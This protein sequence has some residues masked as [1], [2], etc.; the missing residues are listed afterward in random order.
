M[1]DLGE[2]ARARVI[3]GQ[4]VRKWDERATRAD[5]EAAFEDIYPTLLKLC[6]SDHMG[7]VPVIGDNHRPT[8]Y[9]ELY[10]AH[11]KI[12][13]ILTYDPESKSYL[14]TETTTSTNRFA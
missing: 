4:Y 11:A 14:I 2:K 3:I 6:P 10:D 8:P 9:F 7:I 12:F 1:F 5:R 13:G